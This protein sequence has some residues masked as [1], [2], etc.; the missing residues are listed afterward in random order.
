MNQRK[1]RRNNLK[2]KMYRKASKLKMDRNRFRT[3]A[4]RKKKRREQGNAREPSRRPLKTTRLKT[5]RAASRFIS[6]PPNTK[7]TAGKKSIS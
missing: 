7:G 5:K 1:R 2:K 4:K 3:R 6:S